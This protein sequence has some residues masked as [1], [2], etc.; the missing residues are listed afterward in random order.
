MSTLTSVECTSAPAAIGPYSQAVR[1]GDFLYLSGQ[2]PVEPGKSQVVEGGIAAQTAR[3]LDNMAAVLAKASLGLGDVL[4]TTIFLV[5]LSDFRAVNE[6]YSRY[7][8]AGVLPARSTVQVAALPK[9][10]AIEIEAVAY[11]VPAGTA[12]SSVR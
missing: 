1:A 6:V 11:A 8:Q 3:V 12:K 2:L 7:F 5:D 9:N 10:A 4:K